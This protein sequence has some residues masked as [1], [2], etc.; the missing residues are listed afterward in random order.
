MTGVQTCALP[1][2]YAIC[3]T[4]G[5]VAI[6]VLFL[7]PVVHFL[8]VIC[9]WLAMLVFFTV[10]HYVKEKTLSAEEKAES[11]DLGE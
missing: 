1:I 5:L 2:S 10:L 6:S 11:R 9:S 4:L 8:A 7:S 3:M